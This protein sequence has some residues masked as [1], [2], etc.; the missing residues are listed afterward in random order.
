MKTPLSLA[1]LLL[2]MGS[3]SSGG[4]TPFFARAYG[5][6]CSTC[7]SGFPRLNNFGLAF[8]ANNFRITGAEEMAPMFWQRTLPLATQVR[9]T[10]QRTHPGARKTQF[11][12]TQ[13]LAGGLLNKR[14]A[15]YIHHTYFVDGRPGAFPSYEIWIQHVLDE[16]NKVMLKAGQFELPYSYSPTIHLITQNQPL[17]LG[18]GLHGND[19]RLNATMT[20]LLLSGFIPH[21]F[22]WYIAGGAPSALFSGNLVGEREFFGR[23]RDTFIRLSTV[24]LDRNLG[25]F[26][27]FTHPPRS[28]THPNTK[29]RAVR[30][31]LD[32]LYLWHDFQ[33]QAM[34]IYGENSDPQG[35]GRRGILSGAFLEV[36]R[37]IIPWFG[38]TGRWDI[39]RTTIG[40]TKRWTDAKTLSLRLYPYEKIKLVAEYQDRDHGRSSSTFFAVISF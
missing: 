8:K 31:G 4:A 37:M 33:V 11:T 35:N 24:P 12:E 22:R 3:A 30:Y 21:R 7:H 6:R 1:C 18:A 14:T 19:V 15:F 25:I 32:S 26:A 20:G 28:N 36:D 13:L 39:Q 10:L 29:E 17:I 5:F 38:I 9:P 27:Y 34:L 16:P 23:F 2:L 40:A